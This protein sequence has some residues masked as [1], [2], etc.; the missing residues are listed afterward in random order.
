MRTEH[1]SDFE[2]QEYLYGDLI[3]SQGIFEHVSK[4]DYCSIRAEQ[5]KMIFDMVREKEKPVFDFNLVE[6][7]SEK[8]PDNKPEFS[9]G[10]YLIYIFALVSIPAIST[11]IYLFSTSLSELVKGLTPDVIFLIAITVSCLIIFQ[12]LDIILHYKKYMRILNSV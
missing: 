8:L 11:L 7:V 5:Y 1:L 10:K 6:L 9:P 4:C 3:S 12:C 2:I